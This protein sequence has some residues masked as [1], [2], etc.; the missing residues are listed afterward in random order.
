MSNMAAGIFKY[1]TSKSQ[2]TKLVSKRIF[3]DHAPSSAR[4]PYITYRKLNSPGIHNMGGASALGQPTYEFTCQAEKFDQALEIREALRNVLQGF[5]GKMGTENVRAVF[6]EDD[7]DDYARPD[8]ASQ[9]GTQNARA[10][11]TFWF[12]RSLPTGV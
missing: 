6:L 1:L 12:V 5:S 8:D 11:Y 10:D 9:N 2:I 7:S 4:L 3:P